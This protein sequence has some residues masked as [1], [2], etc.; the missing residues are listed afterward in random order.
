MIC[1]YF[2]N[3]GKKNLFSPNSG[4]ITCEINKVICFKANIVDSLSNKSHFFTHK[5]FV[6]QLVFLFTTLYWQ[7]VEV[8]WVF[9]YPA[10]HYSWKSTIFF[11]HHF[12]NIYIMCTLYRHSGLLPQ[13]SRKYNML[14]FSYQMEVYFVCANRWE[15]KMILA[16]FLFDASYNFF[17]LFHVSIII[18]TICLHLYL[19]IIDT[20]TAYHIKTDTLSQVIQYCWIK[21]ERLTMWLLNK[22]KTHCAYIYFCI[23]NIFWISEPE[24]VNNSNYIRIT[25]SCMENDR[26]LNG[27]CSFLV[28][29]LL[30]SFGNSQTLKNAVFAL[31]S[32]TNE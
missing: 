24:K 13:T 9:F 1:K 10:A 3:S 23:K 15:K 8:R 32:G 2:E 18:I 25:I 29:D 30:N 12:E 22:W 5:T 6:Y 16:L 7:L 19:D 31:L 11:L 17:M 14:W 4:K 20:L 27:I 28:D 21:Y 26:K